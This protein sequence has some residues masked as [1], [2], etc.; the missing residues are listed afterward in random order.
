[1][2]DTTLFN[3]SI[4]NN[5]IRCLPKAWEVEDNKTINQRLEKTLHLAQADFVFSLVDGRDTIIG[6]R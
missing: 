3:T 5:L 2:Q 1:M 6:E 4:R